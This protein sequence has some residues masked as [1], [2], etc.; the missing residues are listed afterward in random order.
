MNW[1]KIVYKAKSS[2]NL[3]LDF[4]NC[5]KIINREASVQEKEMPQEVFGQ[6]GC[7][8]CCRSPEIPPKMVKS[9]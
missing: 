8:G 9:L 5:V 6:G 1:L 3:K 7:G 2:T 4:T